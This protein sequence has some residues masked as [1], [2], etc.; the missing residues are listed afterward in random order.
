MVGQVL[1]A[2]RRMLAMATSLGFAI[3][4]VPDDPGIEEAT[5]ALS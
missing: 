2:N 5:F 3:H 1:A 4:D